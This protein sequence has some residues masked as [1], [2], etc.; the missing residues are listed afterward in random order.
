[1]MVVQP[2]T[3]E[4][5]PDGI[6]FLYSQH[7][8]RQFD[9]SLDLWTTWTRAD[10]ERLEDAIR[11][12][13]DFWAERLPEC[14]VSW[15][16]EKAARSAG[17]PMNQTARCGFGHVEIAVTPAG[18]LCPCE[19]LVGGDEPNNPMRL[20]GH[21][22]DG[23]DFL[24]QPQLPSVSADECAPCALRSQARCARRA[25]VVR[26]AHAARVSRS[27][28]GVRGT[29]GVH[30]ACAACARGNE[31]VQC[32]CCARR[33]ESVHNACAERAFSKHARLRPCTPRDVRV[34]GG[35][36]QG[37]HART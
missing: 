4:S 21:V 37:W 27:M 32:A 10:G 11:R 24:G 36:S 33:R 9:P 8:V 30:A 14:S 6:A 19:R 12:A 25:R 28:H 31:R 15:F 3:V 34:H 23:D 2:G 1:M 13:A 18:N 22:D 26:Y 20:P 17:V 7:R 16:D 35:A 5:L 29:C